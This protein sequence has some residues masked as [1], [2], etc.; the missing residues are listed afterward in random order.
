MW[1]PP[2]GSNSVCSASASIVNG[3]SVHFGPATIHDRGTSQSGSLTILV[4]L[5]TGEALAPLD[6]GET[7][8][9][10]ARTYGVDPATI[11]RLQRRS[12]V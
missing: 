4:A 11:C 5:Q 8:S 2:V 1:R 7:L 6:A 9:A 3:F 12:A 10:I